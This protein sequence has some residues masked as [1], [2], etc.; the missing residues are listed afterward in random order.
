ADDLWGLAEVHRLR[1]E[2]NQAMPLYSE[3]LQCF[4]DIEDRY[5][6]AFTLRAI[7]HTYRDQDDHGSALHH[8][9]QAAELFKEIGHTDDQAKT[10]KHAAK[11]R[12]LM[13]QAKAT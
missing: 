8:Y 13:D 4:T 2:Y 5:S 9:E 7:A 10:L 12:Q 3:A 11:I 1:N 6:A